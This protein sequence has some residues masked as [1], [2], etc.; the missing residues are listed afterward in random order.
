MRLTY[1]LI[2]VVIKCVIIYFNLYD[3]FKASIVALSGEIKWFWCL[4]AW[5]DLC[6]WGMMFLIPWLVPP[7]RKITPQNQ[8]VHPWGRW[9]NPRVYL[10]KQSK[11]VELLQKRKRERERQTDR[12]RQTDRELQW[13]FQWRRLRAKNVWF[14]EISFSTPTYI[15][16]HIYTCL[17]LFATQS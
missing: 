6:Y 10:K 13:D 5:H 4:D 17:W 15:H 16:I 8:L 9:K 1:F 14:S 3:I 2:S 11:R 12:D 7:M